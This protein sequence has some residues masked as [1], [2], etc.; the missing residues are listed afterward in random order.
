MTKDLEFPENFLWG[1]AQSAY[2]T[3]GHNYNNV[4]FKFEQTQGNI[5]NNDVC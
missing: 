1:A 5:K 2:Q 3:E 4:C